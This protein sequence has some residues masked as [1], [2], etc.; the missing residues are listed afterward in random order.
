[1]AG[2]RDGLMD[3]WWP[4]GRNNIWYI[5]F[6]IIAIQ[7]FL[8]FDTWKQFHSTHQ[9]DK[10][11][12]ESIRTSSSD[13]TA[14]DFGASFLV[15]APNFKIKHKILV[16]DSW[17]RL[18]LGWKTR[19]I[20]ALQSSPHLGAGWDWDIRWDDGENQGRWPSD[21]VKPGVTKTVIHWNMLEHGQAIK[22]Q[23]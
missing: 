18:R 1:M 22:T 11:L 12:Q 5:W 4:W 23:K 6:K 10:Q 15:L 20:L 7:S 9:I 14:L 21:L 2:D 19:S 8:Q 3:W 13:D 16:K 17:L